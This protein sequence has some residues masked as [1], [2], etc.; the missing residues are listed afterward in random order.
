MKLVGI[1]HD[2]NSEKK[3]VEHFGWIKDVIFFNT[4]NR[5]SWIN[6]FIL[7]NFCQYKKARWYMSLEK[8]RIFSLSISCSCFSVIGM[9][10]FF[11]H[12]KCDRKKSETARENSGTQSSCKFFKLIKMFHSLSSSWWIICR[13]FQF[14]SLEHRNVNLQSRD[15]WITQ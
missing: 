15:M 2:V 14:N 7:A 11:N 6:S 8:W 12:K 10:I 3:V 1:W 5:Y 9:C 4:C 13:I